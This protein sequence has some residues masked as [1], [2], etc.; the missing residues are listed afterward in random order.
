[1]LADNYLEHLYRY[2]F[3]DSLMGKPQPKL[4]KELY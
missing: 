2:F 1:L 3:R 4:M